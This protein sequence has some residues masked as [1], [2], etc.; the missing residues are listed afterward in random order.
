VCIV[1]KILS[2]FQREKGLLSVFVPVIEPNNTQD[3]FL[4]EDPHEIH[5]QGN[6]NNV[7]IMAGYVTHEGLMYL[8]SKYL[9]L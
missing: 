4:I 2:L 6:F 1:L 8:H 7:P 3:A 9:H 5:S